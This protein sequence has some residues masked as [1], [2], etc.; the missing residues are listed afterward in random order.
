MPDWASLKVPSSEWVGKWMITDAK[1][2]KK[3]RTKLTDKQLLLSDPTPIYR[4][5]DTLVENTTER[6]EMG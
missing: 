5:V 3:Q 4:G 6:T 1:E 2:T